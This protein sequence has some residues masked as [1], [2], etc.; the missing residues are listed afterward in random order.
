MYIDLSSS[1]NAITQC[2]IPQFENKYL[3]KVI[4]KTGFTPKDFKK[5][6]E[7]SYINSLKEIGEQSHGYQMNKEFIKVYLSPPLASLWRSSNNETVQAVLDTLKGI[8]GVT[9]I[10]DIIKHIFP[11]DTLDSD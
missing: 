1:S 5:M 7:E 4:K 11:I 2:F 10:T 9:Q 8:F 3:R 6:I